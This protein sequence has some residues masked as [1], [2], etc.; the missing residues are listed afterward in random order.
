MALSIVASVLAVQ[1]FGHDSITG[2]L[3]VIV[4][5]V[6]GLLLGSAFGFTRVLSVGSADRRELK[7]VAHFLP[8]LACLAILY[9]AGLHSIDFA[10]LALCWSGTLLVAL[11]IF[12]PSDL[13]VTREQSRIE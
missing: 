11:A 2:A 10:L 8:L 13:Q 12:K 7:I 1:H 4:I 9:Y 3:A 6:V 5:P